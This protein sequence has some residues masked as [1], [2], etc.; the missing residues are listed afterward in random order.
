MSYITVDHVTREFKSFK[1]PEGLK[2][3]LSTLLTRSYDVK[4]AVDYLSFTIEKG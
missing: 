2:K 1:R 4:K 3:T